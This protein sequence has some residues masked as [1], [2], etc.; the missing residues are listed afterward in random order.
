MK[1]LNTGTRRG[2]SESR[3]SCFMLDIPITRDS[4]L[5][6]D[7]HFVIKFYHIIYFRLLRKPQMTKVLLRLPTI[8]TEHNLH[9]IEISHRFH[10]QSPTHSPPHFRAII[11]YW[12]TLYHLRVMIWFHFIC[13]GS[14]VSAFRI[15]SSPI[16]SSVLDSFAIFSSKIS[17][18]VFRID[19]FRR[20]ENSFEDCL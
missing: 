11:Q 20:F 8:K 16:H 9:S 6:N 3:P 13:L 2:L 1:Y 18:R 7:F 14:V 17:I 10:H 4:K 19:L 15:K 5:Y 12:S